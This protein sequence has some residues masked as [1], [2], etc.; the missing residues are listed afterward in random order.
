VSPSRAHF[1]MFPAACCI[2]MCVRE[3]CVG[4]RTTSLSAFRALCVPSWQFCDA[5]LRGLVYCRLATHLLH[6]RAIIC[7]VP[8][9]PCSCYVYALDAT[10][11]V[12]GG[13]ALTGA[14]SGLV[15]APVVSSA[16]G[17]YWQAI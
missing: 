16:G 2:R 13:G 8:P 12:G 1:G 5:E 10:G 3:V 9:F 7:S 14:P 11:G 17:A 4:H 15:T 6:Q